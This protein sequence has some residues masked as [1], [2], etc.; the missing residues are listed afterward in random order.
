MNFGSLLCRVI[1]IAYMKPHDMRE[2]L[3][4]KYQ[5]KNVK[6]LFMAINRRDWCVSF[7]ILLL[8]F[9]P[10]ECNNFNLLLLFVILQQLAFF[11]G[12]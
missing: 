4:E 11:M 9:S 7:F 10:P 1:L 8:F 2:E 6:S 12:K 3:N 5:N